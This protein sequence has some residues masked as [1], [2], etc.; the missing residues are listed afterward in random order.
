MVIHVLAHDAQTP[1][2]S[3]R[4]SSA[5]A[6]CRRD[7]SRSTASSATRLV[8][9][10]QPSHPSQPQPTPPPA[11]TTPPQNH[12]KP[13]HPQT[14]HQEAQPPRASKTDPP[15][16]PSPLQAGHCPRFQPAGELPISH[17]RRQ[18]IVPSR[19]GGPLSD[20]RPHR[21][22]AT[23]SYDLPGTFPQRL[24]CPRDR[25]H[26]RLVPAH[27]RA[28]HALPH[29]LRQPGI[30]RQHQAAGDHLRRRPASPGVD[31][32]QDQIPKLLTVLGREHRCLACAG[33]GP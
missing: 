21:P 6:I 11:P 33:P 14:P 5:A 27:P 8:P 2:S 17:P 3:K 25:V 19:P 10:K 9:A 29:H 1:R 13:P 7:A 20:H 28:H 23:R 15:H 26:H 22:R 16:P 4:A 24:P 32:L 30:R 18:D 31:R 12:P